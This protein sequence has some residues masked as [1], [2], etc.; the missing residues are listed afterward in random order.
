MKRLIFCFDGT[1]QKLDSPCPTNVVLTAETVLPLSPDGIAQVIFYDEGVGTS[2]YEKFSGGIFGAGLVKNIADGYRFLILNYTP[3][4]ELYVFGF[5]RGA[6]TARSFVGLLH[7]VGILERRV[8]AKVHDAIEL[9]RRRDTTTEYN[10]EL[11]CF[12]RDNANHVCISE[13]ERKWRAAEGIETQNTPLLE[14]QYL[15]VWDTVGALG[16]PSRFAIAKAAD[17]KFLFHDPSLSPFVKSARHAV[18]IDERRKDYEPTLWANIDTLNAARNINSN[19]PDAP[20]QQ[21]WFPGVHC[22]IGGGGNHRGLS[23]QTLD[24]ILDGARAAGLVLDGSPSS[25]IFELQPNYRDHLDPSDKPGLFYTISNVFA[26]TDRIPGPPALNQVSMSARRRWLESPDKLPDHRQYRPKTLDAAKHDLDSLNPNDLGLGPDPGN[27]H[28]DMY[29]V[30]RG[31]Q[32]R[33]IAKKLLGSPDKSDL[34]FKA[35]LNKLDS[36]D[37]IYPGQLLRI[38]KQK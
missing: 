29:E 27:A 5:S 1:W 23:D 22:A 14:I 2:K 30:Q 16:I 31:D 3:G 6:Y 36:P 34:I 26:S 24:W 37:R 28:F 19:A 9:Y 21:Q 33:A 13:E 8:A 4:D 25:R 12:R 11:L 15:G 20:Y 35:N 18:A 17:K 38:P 10:N 32:L 7:T